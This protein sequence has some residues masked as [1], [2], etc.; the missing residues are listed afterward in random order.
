MKKIKDA[1]KKFVD[2]YSHLTV[3]AVIEF[4]MASLILGVSIKEQSFRY[5]D[6]ILYP[7]AVG[8]A[9][10]L[11]RKLLLNKRRSDLVAGMVAM[12]SFELAEKVSRYKKVYGEL[13]N[14]EDGN[15]EKQAE[16]SKEESIDNSNNS[17]EETD[18]TTIQDQNTQAESTEEESKDTIQPDLEPNQET[19]VTRVAITSIDPNPAIK[20]NRTYQ[21]RNKQTKENKADIKGKSQK[22]NREKKPSSRTNKSKETK[23]A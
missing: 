13:S 22:T 10:I 1:F 3:V 6:S 16:E 7:I 11:I 15:T 18:T 2:N 17:K 5:I 19:A 9:L 4:V 14:E 23:E 20:R 12:A 21:S 8:L